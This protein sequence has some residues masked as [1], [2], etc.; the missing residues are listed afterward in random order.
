MLLRQYAIRELRRGY[1]RGKTVV[2][3]WYEDNM[4]RNYR[5]TNGDG[6]SYNGNTAAMGTVGAVTP[7]YWGQENDLR[8]V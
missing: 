8:R 2:I 7:R 5:G 1:G 3:P 4:L 6:D